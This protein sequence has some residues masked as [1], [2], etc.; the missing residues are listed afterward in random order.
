MSLSLHLA[1]CLHI[2][3]ET[4]ASINFFLCPSS[5]LNTPQPHA[6][7]VIRQ[8]ALLLL[9]TNIL[10]GLCVGGL[11]DEDAGRKIVGVLAI[12]HIGPIIRAASNLRRKR[13]TLGGPLLHLLVHSICLF[14][15]VVT[16][17]PM[18]R[19]S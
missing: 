15:L 14:G 12:Y 3:I 10:A 13:K 8:Y 18:T 5:T 9:V 1:L 19:S 6:H 17:Y 7:S 11:I 16:G 2:L 4:P